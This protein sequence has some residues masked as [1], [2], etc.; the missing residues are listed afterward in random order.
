VGI[1]FSVNVYY[2]YGWVLHLAVIHMITT[3]VLSIFSL[4]VSFM[5][6]GGTPYP[7]IPVERLF[8]LLKNGYRMECPIN[9]P[10]NM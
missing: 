1:T 6:T 8:T 3:I 2:I 9:C 4:F 7:G 5:Q 10:P